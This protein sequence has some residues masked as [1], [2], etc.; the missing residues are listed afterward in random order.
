MPTPVGHSLGGLVV[1][2]W[3]SPHR[4]L[5]DL[6]RD[7]ERLLYIVLLANLPDVDFVIGFFAFGDPQWLHGKLTH[8]VLFA[9]LVAG[10]LAQ[11]PRFGPTTARRFRLALALLL[12]HSLMDFL[13]SSR[14]LGLSEGSGVALL[15][16]LT[17]QRYAAPVSV[18]LGVRHKTWEQ[19]MSWHNVL[20]V[21]FELACLLPLLV[22]LDAVRARWGRGAETAREERDGR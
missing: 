12:S 6:L 5:S 11:V 17:D 10:L 22:L 8:G 3:L 2:L 7:R 20:A 18:F 16:P 19:L 13:Q 4:R 15:A 1:A 21:G 14:G 9:V